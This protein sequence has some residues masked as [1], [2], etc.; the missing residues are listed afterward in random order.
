MVSQS[1]EPKIL[2]EATT[3]ARLYMGLMASIQPRRNLQTIKTRT[4]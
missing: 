3:T 1:D 4:H 2:K